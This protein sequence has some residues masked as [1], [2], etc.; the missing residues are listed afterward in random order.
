MERRD[1]LQKTIFTTAGVAGA[2]VAASGAKGAQKNNELYEFRVYHM[3]R[4]L[5]PLDNYFSKALI[6]ALNRMGVKNVGVLS[7]TGQSFPA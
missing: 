1:F 2:T 3:R 6:P 5:A 4:N 7:E